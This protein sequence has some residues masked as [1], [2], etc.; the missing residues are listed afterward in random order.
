MT[1][2]TLFWDAA[3]RAAV[4]VINRN[5]KRQSEPRRFKDAHAA[6]SWCERNACAFVYVPTS[7]NIPAL[8][9]TK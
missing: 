6:L 9:R 5:R 2:Q 1:I 8:P 4:M 7:N 3:V